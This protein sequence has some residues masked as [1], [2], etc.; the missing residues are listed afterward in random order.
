MAIGMAHVDG[1]LRL[2]VGSFFGRELIIITESSMEIQSWFM[3]FV[4][5]RRIFRSDK[6]RHVRYEEWTERGVRACGIRFKY[7]GK[8]HV[9]IRATNDSETLRTVVRIINV[10]RFSHTVPEEEAKLA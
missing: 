10:Y 3:G 7:D 4:T 2:K 9:L 8:I 5:G 6:V 1:V